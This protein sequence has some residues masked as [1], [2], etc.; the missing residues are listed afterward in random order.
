MKLNF[1]QRIAALAITAIAGLVA[2]T[3]AQAFASARDATQ[4]RRDL[5]Q[6]SVESVYQIA[7]G[8]EAKAAAGTMTVEE[9]KKAALDAIRE[10]RFG[11]KEGKSEYFYVWAMEGVNVMHPIKPEWAGKQRAEAVK[12]G[13]GD[14]I[15]VNMINSLRSSPEGRAFVATKFPRPGGTESVPK[16][17]YVM[18][19]KSWNWMIGSGLYMDDVQSVVRNQIFATVLLGVVV[20]LV[21]GLVAWWISRTV[22]AQLGGDPEDARAAM[23]RVALGDLSV[24]VAQAPFGSLMHSLDGMVASLRTMVG[25]IRQSTDSISTAS[26]EIALG[27]M[28]LSQRTETTASNL[29]QASSALEQ[30]TGKVNSTSDSAKQANQLAASAAEV[31]AR[32]G[33]VVSEVVATMQDINNS[34]KKIADIIGVI[35]G[36]AFQTNILALNAAVE[37]ARAGEQGR[38]FAVVASEVRSL[39]QRSADAAKEIKTLIGSSVERVDSGTRLVGAAGRTM[40]EIVVSVQ[41]VS[42][43]IDEITNS[44]AQQSQDIGGV[45]ASVLELDRVTQQ[46]AALVEQSAAAADSLKEQAVSL[47]SVVSAFKLDLSLP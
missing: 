8:Y 37:A 41:R 18:L 39:A 20:M 3:L 38:G 12:D 31:A 10:A 30:L 24:S 42:D 7:A 21:V 33:V 2:L 36:I 35:D 40:D 23:A 45:N 1:R 9:A 32:G 13:D 27:N 5:L 22:M 26:S 17:Q 15:V 46:N 34:S 16:V 28:D 6:A 14:L 19:L 44:A 25:G 4:S 47:A 11:G 29:Q 43:M